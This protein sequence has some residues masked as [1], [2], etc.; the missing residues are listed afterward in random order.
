MVARAAAIA[1]RHS[2]TIPGAKEDLKPGLKV[3]VAGAPK[4]PDGSLEVA[5][6]L[7]E[8]EIPPPQRYDGNQRRGGRRKRLATGML[9]RQAC[10]E[11]VKGIEPSSSAWKTGAD[12]F[13]GRSFH[14]TER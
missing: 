12:P 8:K 5:A 6:I 4:P 10:L 3:F 13:H 2:T 11:Q 14:T 9:S 7:I 1:L